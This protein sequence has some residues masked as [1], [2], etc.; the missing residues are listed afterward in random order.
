VQRVDLG[1]KQR[2]IVAKLDRHDLRQGATYSFAFRRIVLAEDQARC[3]DVGIRRYGA[4]A[5]CLVR[6]VA[7]EGRKVVGLGR[8]FSNPSP[9]IP[10]SFLLQTARI[11]PCWHNS[12]RSRQKS[13]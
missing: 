13:L 7:D 12:L 9:A 1:T 8:R 6:P 11:T 2:R 10:G 4:Q 3:A 5:A